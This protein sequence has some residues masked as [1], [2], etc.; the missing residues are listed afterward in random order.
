MILLAAMK[1]VTNDLYIKSSTVG[2]SLPTWNCN[3]DNG[4]DDR[5][6]FHDFSEMT[7]EET[8]ERFIDQL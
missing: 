7:P 2:R 6:I 1:G 3:S 4:N 8:I 5:V